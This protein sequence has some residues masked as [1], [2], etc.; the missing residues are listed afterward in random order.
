MQVS[1]STKLSAHARNTLLNLVWQVIDSALDG[2]GLELPN[3][4]VID[5]LL[6]PAACFVTLE[7]RGQLRGCI[8]TMQAS[9][10]LWMNACKNAYASGFKDS[11]FVPLSPEERPGLSV[12]ISIL[13]PLIPMV[14]EGELALKE[15]LKPHI[16]GLLL[17]EGYHRSVFLPLVWDT[18]QTPELFI[19]AL[20]RKGG[21]PEDY[22]SLDISIHTFTTEVIDE[23]E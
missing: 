9:E 5:E 21:W 6:M 20:K 22:W 8:G 2:K 15:K 14:N 10:P 16:D 1:S 11:R 19:N 18:L 17:E 4:P 12:E 7:Y 13:S 3:A 23:R